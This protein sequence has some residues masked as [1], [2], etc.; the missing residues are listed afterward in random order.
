M[1]DDGQLALHDFMNSLL[2]ALYVGSVEK[3]RGETQEGTQSLGRSCLS[4][5][6]P[7]DSTGWPARV[8]LTEPAASPEDSVLQSG[9]GCCDEIL[10]R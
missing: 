10:S 6:L 1:G 7:Q 4:V 9:L 8:A 2:N 3:V 5:P